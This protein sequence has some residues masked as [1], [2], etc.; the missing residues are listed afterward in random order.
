MPSAAQTIDYEARL[1][2]LA[3]S[4]RHDP[5]RFVLAAYPWGERRGPLE[6]HPGPDNW[7]AEV[8]AYI[9]DNVGVGRPLRIAIAGGVGPGKSAL[10][11]WLVNW[12]M[13]HLR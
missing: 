5:L 10:M 1:I 12:G 3:A 9:R 4:C 6:R 11:A 13:T 8:L 7:Q 2:E